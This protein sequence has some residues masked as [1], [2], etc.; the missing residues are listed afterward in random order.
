MDGELVPM[1]F[2]Q[3]SDSGNGTDQ[4]IPFTGR[5]ILTTLEGDIIEAKRI[6]DGKP[7]SFFVVKPLEN[8][9]GHTAGKFNSAIN[10]YNIYCLLY[11]YSNSCIQ[12]LEEI[13]I[14]STNNTMNQNDNIHLPVAPVSWRYMN[15]SYYS[16]AMGLRKYMMQKAVQGFIN[17]E[18][19]NSQ[20][21]YD[22]WNR[23]NDCEKQFFVTNPL[24]MYKA[25]ANRTAAQNAAREFFPNC[26][27]H[28]DL[29]DAFRHAYFSALNTHNMGY[30]NAKALGDAHEC[31]VPISESNEKLMDLHNNAWGYHYGSTFSYV[32]KNQFYNAFIDAYNNGQIETLENC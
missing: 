7:V 13:T 23:L 1:L 30:T 16:Y 15:N 17:Q 28:N 11:P 24:G 26:D 29:G 27:L 31:D 22:D 4:S 25:R 32:D 12:Q 8:G 5:I 2:N 21:P 10:P 6:V 18:V 20:D 3:V 14:G 9:D 19:W